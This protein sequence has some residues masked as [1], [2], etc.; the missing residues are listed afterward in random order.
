VVHI[1]LIEDNPGDVMLVERALQEHRIVHELHVIRDGGEAIAFLGRMGKRGGEPC[2]DVLLLD[3]NLPKVEGPEVLMEFRKHPECLH[4]P[5][6]V[7]TSSSTQRERAQ[8]AGLGVSRYFQK[9]ADLDE[10]LKLGA[11]VQQV[12]E[13]SA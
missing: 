11:V 10:F 3:L 4:T 5:V 1:L 2:P 7:V 13:Q 6:I 8:M 9:P 12:I